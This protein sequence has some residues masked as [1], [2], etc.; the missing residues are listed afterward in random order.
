MQPIGIPT[1]RPSSQPFG[2][3]SSQPTAQPTSHPTE[4]IE[5]GK[6]FTREI[7]ISS[8]SNLSLLISSFGSIDQC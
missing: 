4:V 7:L 2:K 3:P 8:I 5:R 1:S 6:F